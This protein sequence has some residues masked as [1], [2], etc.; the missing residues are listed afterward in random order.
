MVVG[1]KLH[2]ALRII[3]VEQTHMECLAHSIQYVVNL[4]GSCTV[5]RD[6]RNSEVSRTA[7]RMVRRALESL[8]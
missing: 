2:L 7:G 8:P 6:T 3:T 4:M 5:T 1:I